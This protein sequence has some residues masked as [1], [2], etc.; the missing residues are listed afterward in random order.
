MVR[1][2]KRPIRSCVYIM[3][4]ATTD[5]LWV[6]VCTGL[7]FSMQAGFLFLETG[8]TRAKNYINVAIKN[9]VD[10]GF[11]VVL[12]W[13][14]GFGLMFGATSGGWFG[15]DLFMMDLS[16][17]DPWM[18]VFFLFQ[19]V[20]AGTTVT[21]VSGAVAERL[22][23]SAYLAIVAVC[24]VLYPLYG[25]WVWGGG[26]AGDPGWLTGIGFADF[27]GSSVVHSFGGWV[28][29]AAILVVGPRFGRFNADGTSKKITPSNLPMAMFGAL[30]LWF[31]WIGFNGGSTLAFDGTVPG[32]IINTMIGGATGLLVSFGIGWW[33][34]GYPAPTAPL[35]GALAGLVAVT[36]NCHVITTGEAV[37]IGGIGA[38]I[39]RYV[40]GLLERNQIDDAVGAVPV[41]LA[42]GIWGTLAVG[43]F[44]DLETLGTGLTRF[45][46]I[47]VQGL[48]I[49]ACA[50]LAF[51]GTYIFFKAV[52]TV[53]PFRVPPDDEI[54]G[55]NVAEH[56]A[57]T[58]LIDLLTSMDQ[59][60]QT[61]EIGQDIPAEPFTEVGQIAAQ[62]NKVMR[63][64]RDMADAAD[65]I[66]EGDLD[67]RVQPLSEHD[68]FGH[69]FNAM[70]QNLRSVLDASEAQKAYLG[71]S[72]NQMLTEMDRFAA[73]DLDAHLT[74][75]RDDDI[76]RLYAGFNQVVAN[77]RE[78][79]G[80]LKYA[81]TFTTDSAGLIE[82]TSSALVVG[83]QSQA[84][85]ATNVASSVEE[86]SATI[87]SNAEDASRVAVLSAQGYD[88][89]HQG[90]AVIQDAMGKM[91]TI[92]EV[93][94]QAA[95]MVG[96]LGDSSRKIDQM[97]GT[98]EEIADQTNLL[99]LNASIEAARAGEHG[100]G[101]A[102]VADEVRK[103]AARTADATREITSVVSEI[104][105]E[106]GSV[107]HSIEAG[108]SEVR[109]GLKLAKNAGTAV[110]AIVARMHDINARV[111]SMAAANEQ[112][113][114]TSVAIAQD[115][116]E[117]ASVAHQAVFGANDIAGASDVLTGL[118]ESL[119]DL[120]GR[121]TLTQDSLAELTH[122]IDPPTDQVGTLK[123]LVTHVN[124]QRS[125]PAL[126]PVPV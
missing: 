66:A 74:S 89:A 95:V 76:A 94:Q 84:D 14:F 118:A 87:S 103:L 77:I 13:L 100:R 46:Q 81:V 96:E 117:I 63:Y 67:L 30:I 82:R 80:V 11:A 90:G 25:H 75:D 64:V 108:K 44:G 39:A 126:V 83:A 29:L 51:G 28:A 54:S 22:R 78:T 41:H 57:S 36:A 62:Y 68:R 10:F 18:T 47:G 71:E 114:V 45:E 59:Q 79:I 116:D 3:E 111:E 37:L 56:R 93:V 15:T 5:A 97:V 119:S 109:D 8:L 86:M 122:N 107:I 35:N 120:V 102:V 121:F 12:F 2:R 9:L 48:G 60:V 58:E 123:R 17:S 55:L 115:V 125:Q 33:R 26:Y 43:L 104:Q 88:A 99:A 1:H 6:L 34:D 91:E 42:A 113:G 50:V 70:L 16:S 124:R 7:V 105:D 38:L 101:F 112:Q 31:G 49:A 52:N 73:G 110:D 20:F 19:V 53:L 92:A 21:I 61:G 27:A 40:E 85:H 23:F 4:F 106:V 65:R 72:V 98:I 32:V 24:S 69:A